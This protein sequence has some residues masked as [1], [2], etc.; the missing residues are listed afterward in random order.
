M[1][2]ANLLSDA[3]QAWIVA[4]RQV[5]HQLTGFVA[6]NARAERMML[7]KTVPA[8]VQVYSLSAALAADVY[9]LPL[10]TIAVFDLLLTP[11]VLN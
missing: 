5:Q 9:G 2:N 4:H 11:P 1:P 3:I 8:V 10:D 6:A 7:V